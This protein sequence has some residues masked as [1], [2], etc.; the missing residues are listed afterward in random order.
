MGST[1]RI[2]TFKVD[3]D[4]EAVDGSNLSQRTSLVGEKE[5]VRALWRVKTT[6]GFSFS[7]FSFVFD[8]DAW[9]A[10]F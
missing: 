1:Q 8:D 6:P 2:I 10:S 9:L 7:S 3:V 4:F 5:S